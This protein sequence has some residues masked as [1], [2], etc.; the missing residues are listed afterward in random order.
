MIDGFVPGKTLFE[1]EAAVQRG[2]LDWAP[3]IQES[4]AAGL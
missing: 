1:I 4:D 2:A 3:E